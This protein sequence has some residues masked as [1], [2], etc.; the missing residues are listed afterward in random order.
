[1][2]RFHPHLDSSPQSTGRSADSSRYPTDHVVGVVDTADQ[3]RAAWT[4]LTHSGFLESEVTVSYGEAAAAAMDATTGRSGLTNL[5]MRIAAHFGVQDDEMAIK[6]RYEQALR[7]GH[8]VV[9]VLAPTDE[10]KELAAQVLRDNAA[11]SVHFLGRFA[12]EPMRR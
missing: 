11:T 6:E 5:A 10:R 3:A 1:M 8:F 4:A 7:D 9:A 2:S 12:I